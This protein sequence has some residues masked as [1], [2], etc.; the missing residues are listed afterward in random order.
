MVEVLEYI[1]LFQMPILP[2]YLGML[3][4]D[5]DIKRRVLG[6]RNNKTSNDATVK[7]KTAIFVSLLSDERER[8]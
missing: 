6:A 8:A 2:I 7:M 5:H 3:E 4:R 1:F